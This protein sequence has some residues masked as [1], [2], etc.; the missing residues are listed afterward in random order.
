MEKYETIN[1]KQAKSLLKKMATKYG[2]TSNIYLEIEDCIEQFTL[3]DDT[4][5][6]P[7]RSVVILNRTL[8]KC[9]VLEEMKKPSLTEQKLRRLIRTEIKR[10]VEAPNYDD[11]SSGMMRR[12]SATDAVDNAKGGEVINTPKG[13]FQA[14]K[15]IKSIEL[16]PGDVFLSTYN[17]FNQGAEIHEFVGI[18]DD[19]TKYGEQFEKQKK[20]TF[21]TVKDC[22][23]HYKVSSLK[24]LEELQRKN[25]YG[26]Q[27][28]MCVKD[29]IDGD[30]GAWF[31]IYQGKWCR[32]SGAEKLSFTL[33]KRV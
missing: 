23:R 30:S 19:S 6:W 21:K 33:L 14:V 5:N 11:M 17:Q 29:L 25:E 18:T 20:V 7:S 15:S 27:S 3:S 22:L 32:G 13:D 24:A 10:I 8:E 4:M 9:R 2:E 16:K 1:N 31:Y 12:R 28:Y 26:Y